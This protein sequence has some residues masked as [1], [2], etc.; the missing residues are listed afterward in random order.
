M[1]NASSAAKS[2]STE[3]ISG[4]A[5]RGNHVSRF[6]SDTGKMMEPIQCT[7]VD[8]ESPMFQELS[9]ARRK[10]KTD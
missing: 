1:K 8:F 2:V 3:Q 10:V 6:F 7:N 9:S 4:I 5:E